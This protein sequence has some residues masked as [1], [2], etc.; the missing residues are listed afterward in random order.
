MPC[1]YRPLNTPGYE[2][3][4]ILGT[5]GKAYEAAGYDVSIISGDRDLLQLATDQDQDP[6]SE[7]EDVRYRDRRFIMQQMSLKN[8]RSHR[9]N[10]LT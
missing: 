3:D 9:Q 10:L 1:R 8:I 2:A 6:H 7:D 4:D 5:L